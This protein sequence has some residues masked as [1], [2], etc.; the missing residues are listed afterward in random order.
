M[1]EDYD[2]NQTC[3]KRI[4][5]FILKFVDK[6]ELM[7]VKF[8]DNRGYTAVSLMNDLWDYQRELKKLLK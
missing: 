3:K 5:L 7:R 4:Q 1:S 8:R 2:L 6:I